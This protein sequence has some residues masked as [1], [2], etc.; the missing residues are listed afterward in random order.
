MCPKCVKP[1]FPE[2]SD[3]H[4]QT[5]FSPETPRPQAPVSD[6]GTFRLLS[7]PKSCLRG[8]S[9]TC[10]L[11]F[12]GSSFSV[13]ASFRGRSQDLCSA[14]PPSL[15]VLACIMSSPRARRPGRGR[16]M[17]QPSPAPAALLLP[18]FRAAVCHVASHFWG[19]NSP[20]ICP[21]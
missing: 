19:I 7:P 13:L 12:L 20:I 16:A 6:K 2:L 18:P 14:R 11:P 9:V 5:N 1:R 4:L 3:R 15:D 8:A 17:C 21:P 10:R